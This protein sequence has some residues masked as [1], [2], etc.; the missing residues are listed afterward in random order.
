[1]TKSRAARSSIPSTS[2]PA[3]SRWAQS[4][5]EAASPD[6]LFLR[7][8]AAG[9]ML[10]IDPYTTPTMAKTPTLAEWELDQLR[11]IV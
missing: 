3:K 10:R 6:E 8:E 9:I 5:T 2:T 7:L 4:A 11:T 1:M